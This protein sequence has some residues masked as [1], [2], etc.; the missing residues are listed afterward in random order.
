[1]RLLAGLL[2]TSL[3]AAPAL[4]GPDFAPAVE[5]DYAAHL[6]KLFVDFHRNPE[7]SFKETR[8]AAIM[9][10]ELRAVGGIEV[11]E[12]VGGTGVVGVMKNGEGPTVLVRADMDGLPLKEDSGV[13]YPSTV[14]QVDIDG[15]TKPVMHACGHDVH[16]T[17][18]IG[19]ARQLA[20]MKDR[21]RGTVVF[22][23]QPAE[24]RIGGAR[25]MME[26]GLYTRFPKPDYAVAFHVAAGVP[27]GKLMLEPGISSS[28]SDSVDI[29]VF[30]VGTHGAAPHMGKDP[31][32]MGAEIVM[33]LQTLVSREIAP[34]SPGVVTVGSFHS[35]FKHNIISDKAELQLTVR[36]DDEGTRK[37]LLDGIKRIAENVGRMNGLPEDKLPKVRVGFES[38]PVTINNPALTGRVQSAFTG[39]FG[40]TILHR[41]PRQSMGAEDFAYFIQQDSGVPGAYFQ[42]GGTPQAEIDA[43]KNGGKP[44]PSHHSPFFKIDPKASV[45]LGTEATTVA[46]LDLLKPKS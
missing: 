31:I 14:T 21:W 1:M 6:E 30:G 42:V 34:L 33:A 24:E 3:L 15:V 4:A 2:A 38:T 20:R 37:K 29:T 41:E 22:V 44:V 19:T 25:K 39:A 46:V 27:T 32:V 43:A 9:A 35:G 26:D 23:V 10:K 17:S 28:S 7:L 11:T 45:T 13:A 12:G 36:S 18:M 5:A 40:E 8:T 16:I